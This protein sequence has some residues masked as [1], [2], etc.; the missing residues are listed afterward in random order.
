MYVCLIDLL[1][2]YTIFIIGHTSRVVLWAYQVGPVV[3][4]L[5][6]YRY[7]VKYNINQSILIWVGDRTATVPPIPA[8]NLQFMA[9]VFLSLV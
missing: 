6:Y 3:M 7:G 2:T 8:K 1:S 9:Q 5:R 4:W